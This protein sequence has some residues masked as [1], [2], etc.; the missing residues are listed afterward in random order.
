M[1]W[2]AG[3]GS[4]R[5]VALVRAHTRG[6]RGIFAVRRELF[7]HTVDLGHSFAT[8]FS[9]STAG[10]LLERIDGDAA[11]LGRLLSDLLP[12]LVANLL[13]TT[14]IVV[15]LL[16]ED[17]RV[18]VAVAAF[19]VVGALVVDRVRALGVPRFVRSRAGDTPRR[20]LGARAGRPASAGARRDVGAGDRDHRR[21]RARQ[22]CP[23]RRHVS[24]ALR[25]GIL[26]AI[27][28]RSPGA[29]R[30]SVGAALAT[31]RDDPPA[32]AALVATAVDQISIVIFIVVALLLMARIDPSITAVAVAPVAVVLVV[33][34]L[35]RRRVDRYRTRSRQ[36]AAGATAF[37]VNAVTAWQTIQLGGAQEA[38]AGRLA[39]LDAERGRWAIRDQLLDR[40]M[41]GRSRP[42]PPSAAAW[43]SPSPAVPCAP[44]T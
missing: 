39:R 27:L 25:R 12:E 14:G 2:S 1:R 44:A 19:A 30:P 21:Q 9:R 34:Q 15:V 42:P 11:K 16:F 35:T 20:D 8:R 36:A 43:Y 5:Y 38:A 37:M 6:R 3:T 24:N 31:A 26:A 4:A 22:R 18:G 23:V 13:M 10:T 29:A 17:W 40:S 41:R 7:R 33:S 32:M 28:H